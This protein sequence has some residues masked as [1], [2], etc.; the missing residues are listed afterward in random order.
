MNCAFV[1]GVARLYN[2]PK[3]AEPYRD[4][5]FWTIDGDLLALLEHVRDD[6]QADI[7]IV[8]RWAIILH[9]QEWCRWAALDRLPHAQT[10]VST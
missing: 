10:V 1:R 8:D 2:K 7:G 5:R 3:L 4:S 6:A 9:A